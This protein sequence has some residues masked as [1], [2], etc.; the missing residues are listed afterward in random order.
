M[1]LYRPGLVELVKAISASRVGNLI[2]VLEE[3]DK[4]GGG[5]VQRR[6]AAGFLLPVVVL[7]LIEVAPLQ[8]RE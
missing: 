2:V 7:S 3:S 5:L 4:R 6:R 8:G 1:R